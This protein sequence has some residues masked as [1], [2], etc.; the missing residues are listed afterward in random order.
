M[1][2]V[3][4]GTGVT[5]PTA[6]TEDPASLI[7]RNIMTEYDS[8][9]EANALNQ[10]QIDQFQSFAGKR[11]SL[12]EWHTLNQEQIDQFRVNHGTIVEG[13][14]KGAP[15]LL[16]TTTGA[17]SG[18]ARVTPLTYTRDGNRYVVLASKLGAPEHPA[19]Y[20][21][22]V[23]NPIVTVE[24]G[25]ERFQARASVAQGSER[26]RLFD[27]HTTIMPNFAEYQRHTTR[28]IPVVILDRVS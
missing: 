21:N 15:V 5:A 10:E 2:T 24:V 17:R 18:K 27:A 11:I 25:P 20:H 23:A 4:A 13:L 12:E 9:E 6:E 19:W 1:E 14:F 8:T 22:L 28:V 3:S 26:D 7:R 16:L